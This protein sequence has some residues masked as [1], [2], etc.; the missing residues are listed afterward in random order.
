MKQNIHAISLC[1]VCFSVDFT[2]PKS[3]QDVCIPASI[4]D[5]NGAP[6]L[7][8]E[9]PGKMYV[10]GLQENLSFLSGVTEIAGDGTFKIVPRLFAQLYTVSSLSIATYYSLVVELDGLIC[11]FLGVRVGA[12]VRFQ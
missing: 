7:L 4:R 10:F 8:H 11:C 3:V 5:I 2:E 12:L 1:N 6:F 9:E